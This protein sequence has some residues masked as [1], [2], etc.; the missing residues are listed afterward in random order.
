MPIDS[1]TTQSFI[2]CLLRFSELNSTAIVQLM[3]TT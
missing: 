3:V 2:L 1:Y